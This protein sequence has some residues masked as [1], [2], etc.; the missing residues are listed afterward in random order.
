VAAATRRRLAEGLEALATVGV[1]ATGDIGDGRP[2]LAVKDLLRDGRV[3]VD[4]IILSTLPPGLS[5]W[6]HL[7]VP[8]RMAEAVAPIPVHHI[9]AAP[10]PV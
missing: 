3:P 9:L 6:L 4:E 2:V 10:A 5:R 1:E 7:D 8:H